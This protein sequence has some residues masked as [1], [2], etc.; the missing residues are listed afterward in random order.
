MPE[1][2]EGR[3][4]KKYVNLA[5]IKLLEDVLKAHYKNAPLSKINE[6]FVFPPV[7]PLLMRHVYNKST[8][9]LVS[10]HAS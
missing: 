2:N 8:K 3:A 10:K 4:N 6:D 5:L 1:F 7:E 9:T